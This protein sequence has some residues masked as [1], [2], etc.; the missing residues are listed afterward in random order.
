MYFYKYCIEYYQKAVVED[1]KEFK[2]VYRTME[3]TARQ[4]AV[5]FLMFII[6]SVIL[7]AQL[8]WVFIKTVLKGGIVAVIA[9]PI[10]NSHYGDTKK[11]K[12]SS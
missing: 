4:I 12:F 9:I 3:K 5:A 2:D 10:L 7:L 11:F 1:R 6:T 8:E